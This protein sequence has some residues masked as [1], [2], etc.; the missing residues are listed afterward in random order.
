M[1]PLRSQRGTIMKAL[2][3]AVLIA[4]AL[5][6]STFAFPKP[7]N[8]PVTRAEV[9]ADLVRVEQAGYRP[10]AKDPNYPADIQAADAK[11]AAQDQTPGA[12]SIGG[13][14]MTGAS[15]A[16]PPLAVND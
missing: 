9:K 15:Q 6:A 12:A 7:A 13:A 3:K 5:S 1:W 16:A 4:C 2:V 11:I 8:A 10:A 14:P